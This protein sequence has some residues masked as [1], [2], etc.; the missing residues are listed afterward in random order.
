MNDTAQLDTLPIVMFAKTQ[1]MCYFDAGYE[2]CT[3]VWFDGGLEPEEIIEYPQFPRD[4]TWFVVNWYMSESSE[5]S[6]NGAAGFEPDKSS[7]VYYFNC[8]VVDL[9][10][11]TERGLKPPIFDEHKLGLYFIDNH[12]GVHCWPNPNISLASTRTPASG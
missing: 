2:N 9:E 12:N 6:T 10:Q 7:E 5:S 11:L 4:T 1:V 3:N 8:E